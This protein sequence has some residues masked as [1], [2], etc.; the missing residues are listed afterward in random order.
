MLVNLLVRFGVVWSMQL[1]TVSTGEFQRGELGWRQNKTNYNLACWPK[2]ANR[3][4]WQT[5]WNISTISCTT[6]RTP[7]DAWNDYH[8]LTA[9]VNNC[10][11]VLMEP[12][13][14][15]EDGDADLQSYSY[16][17]KAFINSKFTSKNSVPSV[18][19]GF[20]PGWVCQR[21]ITNSLVEVY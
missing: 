4:E 6:T 20:S 1:S 11:L 7:H 2:V 12:H 10:M 15:V 14:A 9:Q 8:K 3:I 16:A 13:K 18:L 5:T 17:D 19:W 21:P